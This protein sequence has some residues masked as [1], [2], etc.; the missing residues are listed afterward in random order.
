MEKVSKEDF[1]KCP[2]CGSS[3]KTVKGR[4]GTF[5]ACEKYRETGCTGR[6][7]DPNRE[8]YKIL[9]TKKLKES[10]NSGEVN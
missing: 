1:P 5:L 8:Y 6:A 3:M 9:K 10:K 2:L 7:D 4:F